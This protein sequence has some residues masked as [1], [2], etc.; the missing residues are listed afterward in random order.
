M[1]EDDARLADAVGGVISTR[2][3]M[4]LLGCYGSAEEALRVGPWAEADVLISDISLPGM[5]GVEL[6]GKVRG[7]APHVT[8]LAYTLHED[9]ET[10]FAALRAGAVGYLLKGCSAT[11]LETSIRRIHAGESP[12]S[13]SIAKRLLE[14]FLASP[15]EQETERLSVREETI[16]RLLADGLIYKEVADRLGISPHTVH[17][18]IKKIYGKLHVTDRGDALRRARQLGYL[19]GK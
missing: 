6:I 18:H 3:G 2:A 11:D 16:V 1:V 10:V 9:Q 5:N 4:E 17:G 8:V 7:I 12:M 14:R 19:D 13:P 15:P